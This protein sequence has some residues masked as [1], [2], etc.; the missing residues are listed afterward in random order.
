MPPRDLH[1][2]RRVVRRVQW[3]QGHQG[4]DLPD[5]SAGAGR[6]VVDVAG[7]NAAAWKVRAGDTSRRTFH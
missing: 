5:P 2:A 7:I 4:G 3:T 1:R 6:V